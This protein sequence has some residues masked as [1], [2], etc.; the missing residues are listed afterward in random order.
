[1]FITEPDEAIRILR[2]ENYYNII[3]GYKD[4]FIEEDKDYDDN[5]IFKPKST[6]N[7]I[8]GLYMFDKHLK[9]MLL[10]ILILLESKT[11]AII[12]FEFSKRN[13]DEHYLKLS[14][15]DDFSTNKR[16]SVS[17]RSERK[18]FITNY[19]KS[20]DEKLVKYK[21]K[22][23]YLCYYLDEYGH[24]PLWVFINVFSFEDVSEFYSYLKSSDKNAVAK[25]FNIR[26]VNRFE[27]YLKIFTEARNICAHDERLYFNQFSRRND[28][29]DSVH[30]SNLRIGKS[31]YNRFLSGKND[32]FAV[33]I[34]LKDVLVEAE[35]STFVESLKNLL[36]IL[37]EELSS[38][39]LQDVLNIMGFPSNW[40]EIKN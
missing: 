20:L 5:D 7:E 28:I 6:L 26:E 33:V 18:E 17:D 22:K 35:F 39:T 36:N 14:S 37:E 13:S 16:K 3:N 23:D 24:V 11:K 30:H 31:H 19:I 40:D 34:G 10:R 29:V 1:M 2:N 32:L 4:L 8:Y 21:T 25:E 38:I 27:Q 12:A 15:F 9:F